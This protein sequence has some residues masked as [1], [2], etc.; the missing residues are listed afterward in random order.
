MKQAWVVRAER[1]GRLYD[2]FKEKSAIAIGWGEIGS[3]ADLKTRDK[4][5]TRV[6]ATWPEWKPQAIAMAT[7]Q[8]HRFRSEMKVGDRVV[9]YDPGR[10]VYLVGEV[11]GDYRWDPSVDVDDPNVRS[12]KWQGEVSRD[13]LS[14]RSRNSLGA[15]STLFQLS[16]EVIEDLLRALQSQKPAIKDAAAE[17]AEDDVFKNILEKAIEFTK[18]RVHALDWSDL[19]ELVAGLLRAMGYKTRV[20]P[21]GADRGKDIVASPDGF[22]FEAPRIVVE[23]KHRQGAIGAQA[24]RSF[25]GGRHPQ[26]KGLYVST[27]GFSKDAL[28]EAERA[29]IPLSLMTIDDL[30]EAVIQNFDRLDIETQQ[31]L[32]LKRIYWPA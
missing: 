10:R 17:I 27:G 29:S 7:G 26:D 4:I 21:A 8:L 30:V 28:Y 20:S 15:I 16:V 25:L 23:V 14:A 5:A 9:T 12:V 24:I 3:L 6:A 32:P 18:D 22:G 1:G 2:A 31:L 11:A 19:Q 13:L